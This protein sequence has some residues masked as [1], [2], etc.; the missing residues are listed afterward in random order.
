MGTTTGGGPGGSAL[1]LPPEALAPVSLKFF[2]SPWGGLFRFQ[3]D[4]IAGTILHESGLVCWHTGLGKSVFGC[5]LAA[6]LFEHEDWDHVLVVA[7]HNKHDEWLADIATFTGLSSLRYYKLSPAKRAQ[8]RESLPA[9]LVSTY[10]TIKIDVANKLSLVEGRRRRERLVAGPLLDKLKGRRVLVIYDE[11]TKIGATRTSDNYRAHDFMLRQIEASGRMAAVGLTATPMQRDPESYYNVAR[12]INPVLAGTVTRFYA[13]HV[14]RRDH[15]GNVSAWKNIDDDDRLPGAVTLREKVEPILWRKAKTDPDV[16]RYFPKTTEAPNIQVT[17]SD[18]HYELYETIANTYADADE[19]TQRHLVGLLRLVAGHPLALLHSKHSVA[20]VVVEEIGERGLARIGSAKT[21]ALLQYLEMVVKGQ[22][23][24]VVIFTHF[25][26]T[27]FP[28]LSQALEDNG[29]EVAYYRPEMPERVLRA[30]KAAFQAGDKAVYLRSDAGSRGENLPQANYII[31]YELPS[32]Y[33]T[34]EQRIGR[35]SRMRLDTAQPPVTSQAFVAQHTIEE[36][37]AC[38]MLKRN[39]Y[40][41]RLVESESADFLSARHRRD[42][43]GIRRP[44][45]RSRS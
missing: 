19:M 30:D 24:Q 9:V 37:L 4:A 34:Y 15:F 45:R 7:E 27:I 13:D 42:L 23:S 31:H 35:A 25:A 16:V 26:N 17:L 5:A 22:G 6:Y 43:L 10:E 14:A 1:T 8:V 3:F 33:M 41:D 18:I 40:Q 28:V 11:I 44:T 29:H 39:E 36:G 32:L 2:H 12:L 20:Q 38:L 21:D